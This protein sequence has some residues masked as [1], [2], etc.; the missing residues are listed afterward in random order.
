MF[1]H[2]AVLDPSALISTAP[3]GWF[4][5]VPSREQVLAVRAVG[6]EDGLAAMVDLVRES[7]IVGQ[8]SGYPL[9]MSPWYV[10]PTGIGPFGEEAE[11]I[12]L[13]FDPIDGT[14]QRVRMGPR[15]H[16]LFGVL[17]DRR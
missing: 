14:I 13:H 11:L 9:S 6:T 12:K 10:P 15:V 1:T 8:M 4:V 3:D 5:A 2:T 16:E 17:E 7:A